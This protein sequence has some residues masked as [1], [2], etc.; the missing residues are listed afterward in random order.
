MNWYVYIF[1]SLLAFNARSN[2]YVVIYATVKGKTGHAGIAIDNY[3]MQII[4]GKTDTVWNGTLTYYDMWPANDKIGLF[5]YSKNREA[6]YFRLPNHIWKD[7]ITPNSL[8]D[9]GI[10]HR[11]FYPCDALLMIRTTALTDKILAGYLD[12]VCNAAMP[13]NPR[14]FNCSDFVVAAIEK[15][16]RSEVRAREFIPLSFSTTPNKLCRTLM[17]RKEIVVLKDPGKKINKSFIA[18][19]ILK[20]KD[21]E[22]LFLAYNH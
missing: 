8:F 16:F 9:N 15:I 4:N 17:K 19:R 10:P 11:E 14:Y 2:V 12:S 1:C 18:E 6:K 22:T 7:N 5:H 13:F 20:R 21:P 3:Q